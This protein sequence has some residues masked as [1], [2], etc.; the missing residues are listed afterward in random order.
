MY[1]LIAK[2]VMLAGLIGRARCGARGERQ[3]RIV[4]LDGAGSVDLQAERNV[5]SGVVHVV[6]LNALVHDAE[7]A[8]NDALAVAGEVVGETEHEDRS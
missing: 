6:A 5:G 3:S 8:T 1:S 7:A 2:P 4:E